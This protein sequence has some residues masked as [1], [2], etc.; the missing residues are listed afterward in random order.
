MGDKEGPAEEALGRLGGLDSLEGY[1]DLP[2]GGSQGDEKV[3]FAEV[4]L[5]TGVWGALWSPS[6]AWRSVKSLGG[7]R[8]DFGLGS[9]SPEDL[10][11]KVGVG[12]GEA[13]GSWLLSGLTGGYTCVSLRLPV[14]L[15]G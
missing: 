4:G 2:E 1:E 12:M 5:G 11:M 7:G 8:G 6:Q 15:G 9:R 3:V 14:D 13:L 10:K